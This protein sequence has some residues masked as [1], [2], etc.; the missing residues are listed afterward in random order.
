MAVKG[1]VV[2]D[3]AIVTRPLRIQSERVAAAQR[4]VSDYPAIP[5]TGRTNQGHHKLIATN[6]LADFE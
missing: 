1:P 2:E 3:V 5:G 4:E 6:A